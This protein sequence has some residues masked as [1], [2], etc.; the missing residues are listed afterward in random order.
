MF[1]CSHVHVQDTEIFR[2]FGKICN[3]ENHFRF[4]QTKAGRLIKN[5]MKAPGL[6]KKKTVSVTERGESLCLN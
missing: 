3:F 2:G 5:M 4:F 1:S 6:V